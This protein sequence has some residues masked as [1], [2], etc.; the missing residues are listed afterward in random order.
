MSPIHFEYA[1]DILLPPPGME[2]RVVDVH[3]FRDGTNVITCWQPNDK[4]RAMLAA[5]APIYLRIMGRTMPPVSLEVEPPFI[6]KEPSEQRKE[7]IE[8]G[9]THC[10]NC[11]FFRKTENNGGDCLRFQA[12]VYAH[13]VCMLHELA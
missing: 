3:V 4:E 9:A 11:R 8:D 7:E 1:N 13:H 10:G 6:D 2:D 5:G 12:E